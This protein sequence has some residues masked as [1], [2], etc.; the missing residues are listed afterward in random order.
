MDN[1]PCNDDP[2]SW[3]DQH[4][5]YSSTSNDSR[6]GN[7]IDSTL[8]QHGNSQSTSD[9]AVYNNKAP[10]S[11]SDSRVYNNNAPLPKEIGCST[12]SEDSTPSEESTFHLPKIGI[13]QHPLYNSMSN[14][15]RDRE[16]DNAV[17]NHAIG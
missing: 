5:L 12:L 1:K 16:E 4:Q 14:E 8:T 13:D 2:Q 7:E 6:D 15:L 11:T 10:L 3:I 17:T 9:S